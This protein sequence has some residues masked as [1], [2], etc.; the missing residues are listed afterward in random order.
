MQMSN[1]VCVVQFHLFFF[2]VFTDTYV[3]SAYHRSSE[4][5]LWRE[6]AVALTLSFLSLSLALSVFLSLSLSL[7][8]SV[9][10]SL[11]L[12]RTFSLSLSDTFSYAP[13]G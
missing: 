6:S 10:L 12:S 3:V 5:V 1:C 13:S 9:S 8:L 11:S 2:P 4:E 7:S